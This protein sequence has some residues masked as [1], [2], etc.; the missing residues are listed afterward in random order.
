MAIQDGSWTDIY[1]H[2]DEVT[3]RGA[4]IM[5]VREDLVI[6]WRTITEYPDW[7]RVLYIGDPP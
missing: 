2:L 6:T 4:V 3:R 7:Y 5:F 1:D